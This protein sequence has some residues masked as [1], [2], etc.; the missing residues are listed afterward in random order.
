MFTDEAGLLVFGID[1]NGRR[2]VVVCPDKVTARELIAVLEAEGWEIQEPTFPSGTE[3]HFTPDED[4]DD[5]DF[6][7]EEDEDED[8][9]EWE[10]DT[11]EV[12]TLYWMDDD[13]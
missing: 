10:E 2:T 4:E 7:E 11:D 1:P 13:E 3:I 12:D 9:S 8:D 6:D 5:E